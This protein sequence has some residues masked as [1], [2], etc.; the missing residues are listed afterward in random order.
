M[1][2]RGASWS[3]SAVPDLSTPFAAAEPDTTRFERLIVPVLG[4]ASALAQSLSTDRASGE[5]ALQS[6]AL[7]AW[8][9]LSQ[10][11]DETRA[12]AW[13]LTIVANECRSARRRRW[14]TAPRD[15]PSEA[16]AEAWPEGIDERNDVRRAMQRLKPAD[17]LVL[18]L[19]YL[20]DMS[21][22]DVAAMLEVT[23]SV[24]KSRTAR[25]LGRFQSLMTVYGGDA[26][27]E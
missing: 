12:R 16:A 1:S 24:V 15:S 21:I 8:K 7:K 5:D 27:H 9:H 18:A 22:D 2:M 20:L 19:R 3:N 11:R 13:F 10:L 17:R 6:A 4:P 14:L 23:P 25:A 26:S